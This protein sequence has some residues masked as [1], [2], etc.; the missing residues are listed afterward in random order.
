MQS[1]CRCLHVVSSYNKAAFIEVFFFFISFSKCDLFAFFFSLAIV[2]SQI[3]SVDGILIHLKQLQMWQFSCGCMLCKNLFRSHV[4]RPLTTGGSS[5]RSPGRRGKKKRGEGGGRATAR[6]NSCQRGR[7]SH[8]EMGRTDRGI[9]KLLTSKQ[10][11]ESSADGRA[12]GE[13]AARLGCKLDN[14]PDFSWR[15]RKKRPSRAA[16][17]ACEK[18]WRHV[19]SHL[20]WEDLKVMAMFLTLFSQQTVYHL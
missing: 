7:I 18:V 3:P 16:Q 5:C 9:M 14:Q 20:C 11:A 13:G 12:D 4:A 8:L 2:P 19:C 15:L 10:A 17:R 1:P 6:A